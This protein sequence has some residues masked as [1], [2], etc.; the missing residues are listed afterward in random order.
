MPSQSSYDGEGYTLRLGVCIKSS[1][2]LRDHRLLVS[3]VRPL[4]LLIESN[5]LPRISC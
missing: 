5:V 3:L 4:L 1:L 2:L